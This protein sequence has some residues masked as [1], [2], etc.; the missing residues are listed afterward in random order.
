M[1]LY[2]EAGGSR[3]VDTGG[4]TRRM[5]CGR[6]HANMIL[7]SAYQYPT[8]SSPLELFVLSSEDALRLVEV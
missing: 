6:T 8:H 5:C 1:V 3:I 4:G 2:F 7:K